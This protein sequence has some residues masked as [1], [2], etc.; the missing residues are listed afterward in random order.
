MRE[1]LRHRYTRA[2]LQT[3]FGVA[4]LAVWARSVPVAE[5]WKEAR[6]ESWPLLAAIF[7]LMLLSGL[8]R[9]GRWTLLLRPLARVGLGEAYLM[10][11]AGGLL[12]FVIPIRSGDAARAWWLYRRHAVPAG[13]GIATIVVDKALDLAAVVVAL[14]AVAAVVAGGARG[15]LV[16][17]GLGAAALTAGL[18]LASVVLTASLGPW[19]VRTRPFRSLLPRGWGDAIAAQAFAFRAGSAALKS[20]SRTAAV[21]AISI[22]ALALDGFNFSLLFT[23][24]GLQVNPL[25]AMGAYPA[26]VL[27]F[28]VPSAPGYVG[29]LELAGSLVMGLGLNLAAASAAAATLVWHALTAIVVLA[30]GLTGFALAGGGRREVAGSRVAVFHCGFTYSGGGERIVIEEVLGLRARGYQVECYAPTVDIRAC[31]PDLI[32][33]VG[34]KTFLP[35]LPRGFPFRDA[36][37]MAAAS[38]LVPLY[39][40]RF[41]DFDVILG[42]NQ[43]GAWIAYC[44]ARLLGKRY[45]VYLNQPN[46]LIYPRPIDLETGWLT[47]PDYFVLNALIRPLRGFVR[48]ADHASVL[49][50]EELLVNGRYIGDVIRS[51]YSRTAVDC[52][53]GC[54]PV[55]G[56]PLPLE[57]RYQGGLELNGFRIRRPFVLLTNRH[58]PQKRFDLA[59]RALA[60]LQNR[61]PGLQLVVPG[62]F[63]SHTAELQRMA[64]ELEVED[65]VLFLGAITEKQLLR[66]Y[67]EAAVYVYPAPEEDFGMGVIESMA[68]GVP[69][70]AWNRAGPTVTVTHGLSGYLARPGDVDDYARGLEELL[71]S[72]EANQAYGRRAYARSQVFAWGRHLDVLEAALA[73]RAAEP[74][75]G[76]AL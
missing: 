51:A 11:A 19:A 62:A 48:W 53:A 20:P 41:R 71:S 36:I 13:G 5:A 74:A 31:Y 34:V 58:Y 72:P 40:W 26:F 28:V 44:V 15:S 52:P 32:G 73:A 65:R 30:T 60:L 33:Q 23:A 43:P 7:G 1:I 8:L 66:L 45:L 46:R 47:N 67:S 9:A 37:Q 57:R 17:S 25:A 22:L 38:A 64:A 70:V 12:N 6:V 24:L 10:N 49:G 16:S 59:I 55:P 69:V 42:A 39:A 2:L 21:A 3:L 50:A 54:H 75:V 18:L 68:R 14:T 4:L 56:H 35:Q 76:V 63:T 61:H 27:V 29:T